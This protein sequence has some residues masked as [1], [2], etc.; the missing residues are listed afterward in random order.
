[1]GSTFRMFRFFVL[2]SSGAFAEQC[3]VCKSTTV[4]MNQGIAATYPTFG[5]DGESCF[6]P[7]SDGNE[8]G[9]KL[10]YMKKTCTGGCY[11]LIY[12]IKSGHP[13]KDSTVSEN[14]VEYYVERGCKR[15]SPLYPTQL[16][17]QTQY[18]EWAQIKL[19]E[20]NFGIKG[21]LTAYVTE[22]SVDSTGEGLSK[23]NWPKSSAST[24]PDA[25]GAT[26]SY[27]SCFEE[28]RIERFDKK[29]EFS[30]PGKKVRCGL[31]ENRCFSI[32]T[33]VKKNSDNYIQYAY[34]GCVNANS[35]LLNPTTDKPNYM[36][37]STPKFDQNGQSYNPMNVTHIIDFCNTA[38]CN[39]RVQSYTVGSAELLGSS[40]LTVLLLLLN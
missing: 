32:I 33:H 24:K 36:K 26:F 38:E 1:M 29:K 5:T 13:N 39:N 40:L 17:N 9:S 8:V 27:L 37:R 31:H 28:T 23:L 16:N 6:E 35:T 10:S 30:K 18:N 11:S 22:K 19:N 3:L 21:E 7:I 15:N 14:V 12:S 25:K 4:N 2:F 20:K 34:R